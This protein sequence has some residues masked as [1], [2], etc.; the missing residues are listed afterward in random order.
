MPRELRGVNFVTVLGMN[1]RRLLQKDHNVPCAQTSTHLDASDVNY[2][3]RRYLQIP[4]DHFVDLSSSP[5]ERKPSYTI[6]DDLE[7]PYADLSQFE[8]YDAP[9]EVADADPD[10][11]ED[12]SDNEQPAMSLTTPRPLTVRSELKEFEHFVCME[13]LRNDYGCRINYKKMF[14]G[15]RSRKSY[16]DRLATRQAESRKRKR[17]VARKEA[18]EAPASSKRGKAGKGSKKRKT[19][20]SPRRGTRRHERQES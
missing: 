14:A 19:S 3:T 11:L 7:N 13:D 2:A 16:A 18:G 8:A 15:Q 6:E 1:P 4:E 5:L 20:A 9:N 17:N 12:I 10:Y